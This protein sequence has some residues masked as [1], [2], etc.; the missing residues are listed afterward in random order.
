MNPE[1]ASNVMYDPTVCLRQLGSGCTSSK[2]VWVRV[3]QALLADACTAGGTPDR[4]D[5]CRV[6]L[7]GRGGGLQCMG[8]LDDCYGRVRVTGHRT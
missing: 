3:R 1:M 8:E 5:R 4:E 7:R 2:H 6:G